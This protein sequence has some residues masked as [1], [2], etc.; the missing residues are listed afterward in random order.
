MI[1]L[2]RWHFVCKMPGRQIAAPTFPIDTR[3]DKSEFD[4][5]S[6]L[7]LGGCVTTR[8]CGVPKNYSKILRKTS[9]RAVESGK[10]LCYNVVK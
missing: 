6:L 5:L 9:E 2:R 10:N 3:T 4:F 7:W 1:A 8:C